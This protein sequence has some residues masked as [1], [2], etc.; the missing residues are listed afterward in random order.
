[1][2]SIERPGTSHTLKRPNKLSTGG[3]KKNFLLVPLSSGCNLHQCSPHWL[4]QLPDSKKL[5]RLD[6]QP[7]MLQKP[8]GKKKRGK[9]EAVG[10]STRRSAKAYLLTSAY[11]L[12]IEHMV[13]LRGL[14]TPQY[15]ITTTFMT[16]HSPLAESFQT[17]VSLLTSLANHPSQ[18]PLQAQHNSLSLYDDKQTNAH[19]DTTHMDLQLF[20]I[21]PSPRGSL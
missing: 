18:Y 4:P 16:A 14:Q 17:P 10:T 2:Q 8:G 5:P 12:I 6:Y 19:R 15:S 9:K 21:F 1:M 20:S 13:L 11:N 7:S 3:K